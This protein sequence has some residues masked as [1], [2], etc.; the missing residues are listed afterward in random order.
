MYKTMNS[1]SFIETDLK[2]ENA[3]GSLIKDSSNVCAYGYS[4]GTCVPDEMMDKIADSK[5]FANSSSFKDKYRRVLSTKAC[6]MDEFNM[7]FDEELVMEMGGDSYIEDMIKH[8]KPIA[9]VGPHYFS[10]FE[11][12]SVL[13]RV[14]AID[15]KLIVMPIQ[16]FD[17]TEPDNK[18]NTDL[19][20][21]F[22]NTIESI[23]SK[24]KNKIACVLNTMTYQDA[25]NGVI[26]H[27]VAM[28]MDF[29]N[30][31]LNTIEYYNS[32]GKQSPPNITN[33]MERTTAKYQEA[34]GI[35]TTAVQVSNISSQK[36]KTECG[37]YALYF[38]LARQTG[39]S[40]KKFR[41][42]KIPDEVVTK[43]RKNIVLSGKSVENK[44]VIDKSHMINSTT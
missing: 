9:E 43:F 37:A 22:D 42:T 1:I 26:G 2:D 31:Q 7:I 11:E 8:F 35:K 10:N 39:V 3:V 6:S 30:S 16:L 29:R 21:V 12:L 14:E 5:T 19:L 15:P 32:S 36:S 28:F 17:F 41:E 40:M 24:S 25:M 33:W 44:Y 27:W 4:K 20:H 18:F 13:K 23:K 34:T 38:L